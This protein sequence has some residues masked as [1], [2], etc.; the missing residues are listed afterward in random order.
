MKTT[1]AK[2]P[3]NNTA[4]KNPIGLKIPPL[5][6]K[7]N[8]TSFPDGNPFIQPK[9]KIAA[10]KDKYEQE[11]DCVADRVMRMPE[12]KQSLVNEH[13]TLVQR[14]SSPEDIAD[15]MGQEFRAARR[16]DLARII[17]GMRFRK[18]L[19]DC[20]AQ[21]GVRLQE[22]LNRMSGQV[23]RNRRCLLFFRQH[24][25]IN[26]VHLLRPNSRPTIM[27]DPRLPQSGRC[28]CPSPSIRIQPA[29][30]RSRW[31]ERVIMHELTH[32]AGCL[33]STRAPSSE[34][35]AQQGAD[36]CIGTSK[37]VKRDSQEKGTVKKRSGKDRRL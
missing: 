19:R 4:T 27:V 1:A 20:P 18:I 29:I 2:S 6:E 21:S 35:L 5:L 17:S 34:A 22:V 32:F 12:P 9:L 15:Q 16:R 14:Q 23:S 37:R 3:S 25:G 26:P 31:R 11:A 8:L 30:C 28:R 36:Y 33:T 13:S 7:K 24:F 10:P